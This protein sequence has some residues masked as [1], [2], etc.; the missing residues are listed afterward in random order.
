MG[1]TS[2]LDLRKK[3]IGPRPVNR[4]AVGIGR[5]RRRQRCGR[6]FSPLNAAMRTGMDAGDGSGHRRHFDVIDLGLTEISA[7][8]EKIAEISD[9]GGF[10][11]GG[12]RG[13]PMSA[14]R[15]CLAC[16]NPSLLFF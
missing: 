14:A 2:E 12:D 8:L 15:P 10:W 6:R 3:R 4:M 13:Q 1:R 11:A 9:L 16:P 7:D 5:Q